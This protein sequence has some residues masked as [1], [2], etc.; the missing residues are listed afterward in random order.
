MIAPPIISVRGAIK[1][2]PVGGGWMRR[3]TAI[4]A[5][6]GVNLDVRE[7][8]ALGLVGESGCGKSTLT[9]LILGIEAP[10]TGEITLGG[11]PAGSYRR[12]ERAKLIQPV[13]QDPYSSLNPRITV[14]GIVAAPLEVCREGDR[15]GRKARVRDMLARVGLADYL[16]DAYPNQLSGGQRQRVA[17]AR[18]L[19]GNPKILVCDEPT[20]ALD[21]SVQA[22]IL[23]L[24][25]RLH[26]EYKLTLIM[27]SH[28]LAVVHHIAE[29]VAV[30]ESGIIVEDASTDALFAAPA[31]PYSSRLLSSILSPLPRSG[32]KPA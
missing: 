15:A 12:R 26:Q 7:G 4:Q 17:I 32:D 31:H 14:G 27:I 29:R 30:M 2:Y 1:S 22:Q 24:L 11:R 25:S 9:R 8:E 13:F 28:N 3:G 20:S 23:N 18:A 5:L 6:R 16:F 10:T 21:V 19:V